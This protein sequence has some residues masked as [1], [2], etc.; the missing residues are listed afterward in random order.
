MGGTKPHQ[1]HRQRALEECI[2]VE[3]DRVVIQGHVHL[4]D[5]AAVIVPTPTDAADET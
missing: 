2:A 1:F 3:L 4:I 5:R